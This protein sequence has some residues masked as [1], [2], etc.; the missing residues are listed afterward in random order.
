MKI[1]L[2]GTGSPL[3]DPNRAGPSTLV[4][5]EGTTLL[6]DCGRGVLMRLAAAMVPVAS[7]NALLLTHLHSD[8]ITDLNDVITSHWIM[9]P[10]PNRLTIYGPPTTKAV[11]DATIAALEHDIKYRQDHHNDLTYRPDV[12]VGKLEPDEFAIIRKHPEIGHRI[13]EELGKLKFALPGVL[14]HHERVDG[15]GYPHNLVGDEIPLMARILAV[16]DAY[17]AMTSSRVYRTAMGQQRAV[18]I[19]RSGMQT[20]WD[21]DVVE[22]CL[23][24]IGDL[25]VDSAD[26]VLD[27]P[28]SKTTDWRQVSQALRVL[29]L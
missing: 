26:I 4:Q 20:Q 13:L 18:D 14:Y 6:F 1:T 21:G 15:T 19:L 28:R 7:L 16:S 11:V 25:T 8:H 22:A 10:G 17:D 5:A 2:L 12:V 27:S 9:S 29:Q 23:E 3:P 24:Y